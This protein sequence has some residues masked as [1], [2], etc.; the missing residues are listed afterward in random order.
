MLYYCLP[1]QL[2]KSQVKPTTRGLQICHT[3]PSCQKKNIYIPNYSFPKKLKKSNQRLLDCRYAI[4][5][6]V[7]GKKIHYILIFTQTFNEVTSQSNDTRTADM[8]YKS[9]LSKT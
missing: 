2:R 3:N 5:I 4:Q 8:P 1:K 7:V 9:R 6:Q